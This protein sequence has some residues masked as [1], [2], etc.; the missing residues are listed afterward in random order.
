MQII[1]EV[2]SILP[3]ITENKNKKTRTTEN[4]CKNSRSSIERFVGGH[5]LPYD[6]A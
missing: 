6:I 5:A 4:W 3:G 2:I 1:L